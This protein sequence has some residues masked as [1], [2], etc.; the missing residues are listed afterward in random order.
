MVQGPRKNGPWPHRSQQRLRSLRM[1]A[2][3]VFMVTLLVHSGTVASREMQALSLYSLHPFS[4]S[5]AFIAASSCAVQGEIG[6]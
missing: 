6:W 2:A 4:C 5:P 1:S 3:M